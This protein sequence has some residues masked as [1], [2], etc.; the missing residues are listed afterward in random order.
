MHRFIAQAILPLALLSQTVGPSTAAPD[1][2]T[3][4]TSKIHTL[5]LNVHVVSENRDELDKIEG[6]FAKAYR[7][8]NLSF[9]YEQPGKLHYEAVVL[10]AHIAYTI[11]GNKKFTSIPSVHMHEVEDVTGAPLKK[12]TLLD[13]GL[14][15]PEFLTEYNAT[16]TGMHGKYVIYSL[17]SKVPKETSTDVVWMDPVTHITFRRYHYNRDGKFIN[18]FVYSNPIQVSPGLYVPTQVEVYNQY[19]KLAA[20]SNYTDIKA[21]QPISESIFDF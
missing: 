4:S 15:S 20:V 13:V 9:S 18:S 14:I 2:N 5:S 19:N 8:H 10:G 16:Y 12:Q 7:F 17:M 11:N 6:D 21:N 1:P 3:F